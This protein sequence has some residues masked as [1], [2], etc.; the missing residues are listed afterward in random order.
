MQRKN[1]EAREAFEA[2]LR[3][4]PREPGSEEAKQ[5]L[6]KIEEASKREALLSPGVPSGTG[7]HPSVPE[8]DHVAHAAA[9]FEKPWAPPDADAGVPPTAPNVSCARDE[10]WQKTQRKILSQL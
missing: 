7:A 5:Y 6:V 2:Y 8:A 1:A 3:E 9:A 4:F 10:V